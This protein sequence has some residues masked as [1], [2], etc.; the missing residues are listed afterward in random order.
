MLTTSEVE[1]AIEAL[2]GK[3]QLLKDSL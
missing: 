3:L 2:R 1:H